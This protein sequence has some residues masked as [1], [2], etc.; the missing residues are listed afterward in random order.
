MKKGLI[1]ENL[2]DIQDIFTVRKFVNHNSRGREHWH[3]NIE[4]L[5]FVNGTASTYCNGVEFDVRTG[6]ILFVNANEFHI[7]TLFF[8]KSEFYCI[9]INPNFFSNFIGNK[10]VV[11]NN[12]ISDRECAEILDYIIKNHK[13]SDYKIELEIRNKLYSFFC[14]LANRYVYDILS[15]EDFKKNLKKHD[16]ISA[17]LNYINNY[18]YNPDISVK[19][20][21]D[22]FSISASYLTHFFKDEYGKNI[23]DYISETRIRHAKALLQTTNMPIGEVAFNCGFLDANF[24]SRKFKQITGLTPTEYKNRPE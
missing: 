7:G 14:I 17:I 12:L 1:Y 23:S 13:K 21:A 22:T 2:K 19:H 9:Q 16:K 24:F 6:D 10:Y 8:S 15:E 18:Y 5:Y 11:F 4:I 20:I 3:E